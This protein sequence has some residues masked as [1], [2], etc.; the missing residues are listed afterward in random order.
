MRGWVLFFLFLTSI[1]QASQQAMSELAD[2]R[3]DPDVM[4]HVL[5][6]Y[7]ELQEGQGPASNMTEQLSEKVREDFLIFAQSML[8]SEKRNLLVNLEWKNPYYTA[9]ARYSEKSLVINIWG[10]FLRA[11]GMNPS[12]M[13]MA[14]CHELGH[15]IGGEPKQTNET[16]E[17]VT[18]EGQSD[19]FAAK[20]CLVDFYKQYPQYIPQISFEVKNFCKQSSDCEQSL[21]S[22]LQTF[23]FLQKWS[24]APYQPVSISKTAP[25]AFEFI[26]NTYPSYQCRLDTF[27]SA[28]ICLRDKYKTCRPPPCWWPTFM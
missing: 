10:G 13:A 11:P 15:L 4:P 18:V 28:A 12:V 6:G 21:E 14:L 19:F 17:N 25:E 22:G 24:F 27:R 20:N 8:G 23:L 2:P 1:A 5:R 7:F 9:N 16:G 26:P 3:Q